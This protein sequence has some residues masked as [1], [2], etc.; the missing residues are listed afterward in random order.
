[1]NLELYFRSE[2]IKLINKFSYLYFYNMF[3][4]LDEICD[5]IKRLELY[6]IIYS[7]DLND[8]SLIIFLIVFCLFLK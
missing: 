1:M 2:L 6:N 4:G 5:E 7:G 3:L 8:G